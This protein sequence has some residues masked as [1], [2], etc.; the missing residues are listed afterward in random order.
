M[1][2]WKTFS[3]II[4][5]PGEAQK[6]PGVLPAGP[7]AAQNALAEHADQARAKDDNQQ[8]DSRLQ[9]MLQSPAIEQ[10]HQTRRHHRARALAI[11]RQPA[12]FALQIAFEFQ[13]Q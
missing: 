6:F 13:R 11:L 7:D 3:R 5:M 9:M 12:R 4:V 1:R 8:K 10:E 2:R